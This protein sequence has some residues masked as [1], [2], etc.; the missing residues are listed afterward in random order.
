[1]S[2][3]HLRAA[4]RRWRETGSL[5]DEAAWL[6]LRL[7]SGALPLEVL[8]LAAYADHPAACAVLAKEAP[9]PR[10]TALNRDLIA[11]A[12]GR[13][14]AQVQIGEW[15]PWIQVG[16]V[17]AALRSSV[18]LRRE[19]EL[20]IRWGLLWRAVREGDE[21][22][23]T[24]ATEG[25]TPAAGGSSGLLALTLQVGVALG[26]Q[27]ALS[28]RLNAVAARAAR[29]GTVEIRRAILRWARHLLE[30]PESRL[31]PDRVD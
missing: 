20:S 18:E 5:E 16:F 4:E 29:G 26:G 6:T 25:G 1:M 24:P 21:S 27:G 2:D 9:Y 14:G 31:R 17:L 13:P 3:D 7:R 28:T 10:A 11:L 12:D 23:L 30:Q 19:E 22:A 8:E 15:P